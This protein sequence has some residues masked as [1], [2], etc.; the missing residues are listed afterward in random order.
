MAQICTEQIL[1]QFVGIGQIAVMSQS[2]TVRAVHIER[3]GFGGTGTACGGIAHMAYANI[4]HKTVHVTGMENVPH[5]AI[6]FTQKK[7]IILERYNTCRILASVL[8]Y[9]Q[10]IIKR[11]IYMGTTDDADNATHG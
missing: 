3:L 9:S 10:R 6:V 5:Q 2:N 1:A 11:L 7:A 4:A 8:K